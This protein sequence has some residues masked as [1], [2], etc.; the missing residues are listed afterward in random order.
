MSFN[1]L[2]YDNCSYEQQLSE[3]TG[4][5]FYQLSTPPNA[6]NACHPTD[7]RIRLQNGG[8]ALNKNNNLIDIDSELIGITRNLSNCSKRKYI[9]TECRT[10]KSKC[11][12]GTKEQIKFDNC[13]V[14][15]EDTRLSNP[16]CN[17]RGTGWNRWEWLCKNPQD[18]VII[19][20]E[21]EID[22]RNLTKD[23]H[24]PCIPKPL[25]QFLAYP[26]YT[27]EEPC[28]QLPTFEFC[29]VPTDPPSIQWQSLSTIDNY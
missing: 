4:P 25:D 5:G 10:D 9:P 3:T 8:V 6:C 20:Y 1:K 14:Q 7:P 18:Q 23:S 28:E 24:R 22:S 12:D 27:E 16:S 29:A 17:L 13:F 26:D 11:I 19:P 2:S 15:S 21:Y